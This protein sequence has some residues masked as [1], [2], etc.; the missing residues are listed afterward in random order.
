MA[1]TKLVKSILYR[2]LAEGVYRDV[3]TKSSSYYYFLGQSLSWVDENNPPTP[4]DSLTYEHDVRNEIITIKEIKPSDVAF[5]I[6]R[7]DWASD[8]VYDMYDDSYSDQVLGVNIISGGSG[9]INI[10]DIALEITGGGGTG[11]TAEIGRAHV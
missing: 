2:A 3:V 11:A 8:V 7:R 4:V 5:V 10:E 1:D 6:K 9:Y